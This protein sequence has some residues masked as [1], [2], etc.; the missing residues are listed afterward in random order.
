MVIYACNYGGR[1][2]NINLQLLCSFVVGFSPYNNFFNNSQ[3]MH[4]RPMSYVKVNTES[5]Y[6]YLVELESSRLFVKYR[7]AV[8][9]ESKERAFNVFKGRGGHL[10]HVTWTNVRSPFPGMRLQSFA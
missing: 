2:S 9:S 10:G 5:S 7:T 4:G 8:T 6:I 1:G 3:K